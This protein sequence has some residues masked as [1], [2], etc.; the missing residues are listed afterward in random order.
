MFSSQGG[1][2]AHG[3]GAQATDLEIHCFLIMFFMKIAMKM[4]E[5]HIFRQSPN[6][7]ILHI[8]I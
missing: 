5:Q 2:T 7:Y 3:P 1:W 4:M 8:Y 6:M